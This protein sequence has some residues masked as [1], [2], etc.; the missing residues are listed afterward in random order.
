[1]VVSMTFTWM[2]KSV[3]S[4]SAVSMAGVCAGALVVAYGAVAADSAEAATCPAAVESHVF[5]GSSTAVDAFQA[6]FAGGQFVA[7]TIE[8]R[9]LNIFP[10]NGHQKAVPGDVIS[11]DAH[12]HFF[13]GSE[14]C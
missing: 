13:V 11:K 7:P 3:S 4:A 2:N 9:D 8:T 5:S 12:G 10:V 6:W 1:M 14:N